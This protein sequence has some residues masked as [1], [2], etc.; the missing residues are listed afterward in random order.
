MDIAYQVPLSIEFYR[1]EYWSGL[2][3]PPTE[4]L[5]HPGMDPAFLVSCNGRW[6]LYLPLVPPGKPFK[7]KENVF[8]HVPFLGH[9]C[10]S[11]VAQQVKNLRTRWET[12]VQALDWEDPLEKEKATHSSFLAW[13]IPWTI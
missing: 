1:Q 8:I 5:P 3:Y 13:R 11:L 7:G 6:V 12:W 10:A 9:L 4:D 2:P